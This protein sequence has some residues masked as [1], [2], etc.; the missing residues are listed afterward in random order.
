MVMTLVEYSK[1]LLSVLITCYIAISVVKI[2]YPGV[3]WMLFI[4]PILA[5]SV[6][7]VLVAMTLCIYRVLFGKWPD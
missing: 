6:G 3:P 4:A 7:A 2:F 5:M 1:I